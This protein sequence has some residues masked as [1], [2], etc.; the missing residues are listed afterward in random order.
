MA[1]AGL[2][3][4]IPQSERVTQAAAHAIERVSSQPSTI[5]K[6]DSSAD[7][8]DSFDKEYGDQKVAKLARQVT[9]HSI[10]NSDGTYPNPF[11]GSNDP[12]LDPRSGQFKP[13]VWM[14]TLIG[15]VL[16]EPRVAIC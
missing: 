13:E 1:S 8:S 12:A 15:L 16:I 9:Q 14:R 5:Q 11:E 6:S 4:V 10:K 2:W 3:G 7:N